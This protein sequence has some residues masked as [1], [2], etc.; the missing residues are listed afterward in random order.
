MQL[1][2]T[3]PP[4][5]DHQYDESF[6]EIHPALTRDEAFAEANRCLYCFDAPCIQACPTHIDIPSFIKKIASANL[7]GSARVILDANP[8]GHSCARGCPVDVLCEGACVMHGLH[9]RPIEIRRLQRHATDYVME[10]K[11]MLFE[12]GAP[13]GKKVAIV[14]A[15]PAGL[16]AAQD[17]RRHGYAVTIFEGRNY[18]GGLNTNGI[19]QYKMRPTTALAEAELVL[20][21]GVELKLD[22]WVGTDVSFDD[23]ARDY[24][25][26]FMGIGLGAT[27]KLGIPGEDL[28][29]VVDALTFIEALKLRPSE[30]R[31]GRRVVVIGGGNTAIDA[32]TQSARLGA[33]RVVMVYRRGLE[34]MSAYD[35]E[36]ELAKHDGVEFRLSTVPRRVVGK[37]IAE[38]LE[39]VRTD[40][41]DKVIAGSE[42]TLEADM[43]V[44]AI[45]QMKQVGLWAKVPGVQLEGGKPRLDPQSG[46]TTN[47]KFFAGGDC[48]NGGKEIVNAAAEGKRAAA[49]IHAYLGRNAS[50]RQAGMVREAL[51]T[52]GD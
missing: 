26:V 16:S 41:H 32:A 46:Q 35:H 48:A 4:L 27:N 29:G 24:D 36:Q 28:P 37:D 52:P 5:T 25:A 31:V 22:T 14:G 34:H 47:P 15:G 11:L 38:G 50:K 19:A 49:G 39:C 10:R 21:M 45:G 6:A 43:I 44:L 33:D 1:K 23:L 2:E 13:N 3:A 51:G 7:K 9:R 18:A 30:V 8:M 20:A 40:A 42:H 17:L 12:P